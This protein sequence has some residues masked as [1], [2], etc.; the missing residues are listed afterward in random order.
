M[1]KAIYGLPGLYL[2]GVTGFFLTLVVPIEMALAFAM[3]MG[4]PIGALSIGIP[5]INVG[6]RKDRAQTRRWGYESAFRVGVCV[7]LGL[8]LGSLLIGGMFTSIMLGGFF[9]ACGGFVWSFVAFRLRR[10]RH[11]TYETIFRVG[12]GVGVGFFG[13]ASFI[14]LIIFHP[15]Y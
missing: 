2:G 1:Y 14:F 5:L 12:V 7:F 4:V 11:R 10:P 3:I 6:A 8:Y 15:L 13:L 9:G